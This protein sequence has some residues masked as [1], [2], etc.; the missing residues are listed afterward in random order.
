MQI[1]L[2]DVLSRKAQTLISTATNKS[3]RLS[4][5]STTILENYLTMKLPINNIRRY[6]KNSFLG[7]YLLQFIVKM[8]KE[9]GMTQY[10]IGFAI[11]CLCYFLITLVFS[12]NAC[13]CKNSTEAG[14]S[15]SLILFFKNAYILIFFTDAGILTD[16]SSFL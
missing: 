6:H 14:I 11:P 4:S 10:L 9:V 5:G 16:V 15:T 1:A 13:T 8:I 2:L 7:Q 12:S 3:K